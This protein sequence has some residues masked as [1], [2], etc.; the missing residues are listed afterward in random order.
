[1]SMCVLSDPVIISKVFFFV[2][3]SQARLMS[4]N[5]DGCLSS[6]EKISCESLPFSDFLT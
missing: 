2:K 5:Y 3:I 1:M 4:S 6:L